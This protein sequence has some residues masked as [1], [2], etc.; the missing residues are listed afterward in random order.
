MTRIL[1]TLAL[2]PLLLCACS[3]PPTPPA[4]PPA[5]PQ[6]QRDTLRRQGDAL[7]GGL[8]RYINAGRAAVDTAV[9]SL[10]PGQARDYAQQAREQWRA[11]TTAPI[12]AGGAVVIRQTIDGHDYIITDAMRGGRT[13][14]PAP[15]ITKP[16]KD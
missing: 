3:R 9:D 2:A 8:P 11:I 6:Q 12:G 13:M 1:A 15:A 10:P 5:Q 14:T 16:G 7:L 4:A